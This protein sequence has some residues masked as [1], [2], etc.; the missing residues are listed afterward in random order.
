M[1]IWVVS[2]FWLSWIVL[3]GRFAYRFSCGQMFSFLLV[4]HSGVR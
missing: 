3:L 4:I 1:D 2:T